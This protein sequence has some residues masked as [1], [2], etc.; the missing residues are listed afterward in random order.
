MLNAIAMIDKELAINTEESNDTTGYRT[1]STVLRDE[2]LDRNLM[3]RIQDLWRSAAESDQLIGH[4]AHRMP[5]RKIRLLAEV[6]FTHS[7]PML[8]WTMD[9]PVGW[10]R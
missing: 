9:L 3:I 7:A 5:D 1:L 6:T 2:S 8:S 4:C 10:Y